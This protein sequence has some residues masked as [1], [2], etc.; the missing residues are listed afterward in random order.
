MA[1]Y[2]INTTAQQEVGIAHIVDIINTNRAAEDPPKSAITAAQW[3]QNQ[4]DELFDDVT[5][6]AKRQ[7]VINKLSAAD[8]EALGV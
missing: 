6:S 7:V 5:K 4:C 3:L 8:K 1:T 2:T